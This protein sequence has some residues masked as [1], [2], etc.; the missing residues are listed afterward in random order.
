MSFEDIFVPFWNKNILDPPALVSLKIRT[1]NPGQTS[2]KLA[3]LLDK[4]LLVL[5]NQ[6][7]LCFDAALISRLLYRCRKN[8][9]NDKGYKGFQKVNRILKSYIYL[10]IIQVLKDTRS[11]SYNDKGPSKDMLEWCLLTLQRFAGLFHRLERTCTE[12]AYYVHNHITTGNRWHLALLF[13][14]CLSR[15]WTLSRYLLLHVCEWYPQLKT[16]LPCLESKE[17]WLPSNHELPVDLR[18]WLGNPEFLCDKKR[19]EDSVEKSSESSETKKSEEVEGL[20]FNEDF[21]EVVSRDGSLPVTPSQKTEDMIRKPE[22]I[23]KFLKEE[24]I[25]RKRRTKSLT[26]DLS[27]PEWKYLRNY[28][29]KCLTEIKGTKNK[30]IFCESMNKARQKMNSW[31]VNDR[32]F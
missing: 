15:V 11:A 17:Q 12:T 27:D 29:K 10:D 32:F 20:L 30:N 31:I 21:G 24:E 18:S 22:D 9:R 19:G 7:L 5:E 14:A 25:S 8:L 6:D 2:A 28:L 16:Y 4:M 13:L 3:K 23:E 1:K 26:S